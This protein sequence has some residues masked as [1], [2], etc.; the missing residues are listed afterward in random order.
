MAAKIVPSVI[1]RLRRKADSR[2]QRLAESYARL[3]LQEIII[4]ENGTISNEETPESL[5]NASCF[6]TVTDN[7]YRPDDE[8]GDP[9]TA[10]IV[11]RTRRKRIAIT[12]IC[13]TIL[14][15]LLNSITGLMTKLADSIP[16]L[17]V[18]LMRL[19]LQFVFSI[20]PTIFFRDKLA[21]P[22]KRIRFLVLRGVIGAVALNLSVYTI[23]HMALAD[24]R[25]IFYTSPVYVAFLG[26]IFLKEKVSKFDFFATLMSLGGVVL[27][28]RPS[29]LFGSLGKSSSSKQVWLPTL[30]AVA[31]SFCFACSIV[32]TR[33]LSQEVSSRVVVFYSTMVASTVTFLP[34]LISGGIKYPDCG[35]YD[36]YYIIVSAAITYAGQL[37]GTKALSLEK[38][39]VVSLVRTIGI[40]FSF[41]LQ[42]TVLGVA[43]NGLSIGGAVLVLL[44]NVTIFIK[45]FLEQK[46]KV[47]IS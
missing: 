24:A 23:K 30:L 29:F 35:T 14:S 36:A 4:T 12:G 22:W 39:S 38:A 20:P 46:N 18:S 45:T 15:S 13:L 2:E 17:E 21:H 42:L 6:N 9:S 44:C 47:Y 16:S 43:A 40:A 28:G 7:N 27:I 3:E 10:S 1:S 8:H 5:N 37:V 19:I 41:L 34:V 31:G 32:I 11:D 33:K 26:R 25:V